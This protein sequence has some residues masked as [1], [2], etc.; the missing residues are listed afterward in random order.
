MTTANSIARELKKKLDTKITKS[1]ST[2]ERL[3]QYWLIMTALF[4]IPVL[5]VTIIFVFITASIIGV[6]ML[7]I[8]G[9]MLGI[10]A[11]IQSKRGEK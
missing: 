11:L 10:I 6:I 9:P 5:L 3:V 1:T 2:V 4:S 8:M 7:T